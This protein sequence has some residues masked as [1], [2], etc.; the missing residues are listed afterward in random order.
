[1][2]ANEAVDTVCKNT[3][4]KAKTDV[5]KG[6]FAQG[7]KKQSKRPLRFAVLKN[8][9][10]LTTNQQATLQMLIKSEPKLYRAYLLK[11]IFGCAL[12]Y[13][14]DKAIVELEKWLKWAQCSR[15][16][17]FVELGGKV[18]RHKS[19]ILNSFKFRLTNA[20]IEAIN[21]RPPRKPSVNY[22]KRTKGLDKPPK[23]DML[24]RLSF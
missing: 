2:W 16:A 7:G 8:P 5:A 9:E 3:V 4:K 17:E 10:N 21:N 11:E 12:K 6:M 18:K 19:A 20:R 23:Y 24:Y 22:K 13:S 14:Y 15:I 1:M